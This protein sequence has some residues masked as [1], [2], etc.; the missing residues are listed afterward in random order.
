MG[1]I[2][3]SYRMT[4]S[5]PEPRHG[6]SHNTQSL[7][8]KKKKE[9]SDIMTSRNT[10]KRTLERKVCTP[11]VLTGC[12]SYHNLRMKSRYSSRHTATEKL[13]YLLISIKACLFGFL[14][15]H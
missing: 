2:V 12:N 7:C 3:E 15:S 14:W 5:S 10:Q 13:R 4:Q 8:I 11:V 1:C 6:R 9:I